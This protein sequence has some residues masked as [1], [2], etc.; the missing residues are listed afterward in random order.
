MRV[1]RKG[2]R[3][4]TKWWPWSVTVVGNRYTTRTFKISI[5]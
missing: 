3:V 4:I 2:R 1:I 5:E